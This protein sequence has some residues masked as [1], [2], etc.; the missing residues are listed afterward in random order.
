MTLLPEDLTST[1]DAK[2]TDTT[3]EG[4]GQEDP[5]EPL[6]DFLRCLA[7]FKK[8][9]TVATLRAWSRALVLLKDTRKR[10]NGKRLGVTRLLTKSTVAG[11]PPLCPMATINRYV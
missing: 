1:Q 3:D 4:A 2:S 7:A 6:Q 5:D 11:V 9:K 8:E 10:G